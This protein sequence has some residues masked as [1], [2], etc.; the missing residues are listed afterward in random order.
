MNSDDLKDTP[1][2]ELIKKLEYHQEQR[3]LFGTGIDIGCLVALN[4]ARAL[5]EYEKEY[6]E[7]N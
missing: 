1:L 7:K 3:R 2:Q 6:H 5:L 4:H